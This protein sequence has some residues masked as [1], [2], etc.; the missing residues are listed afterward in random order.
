MSKGSSTRQLL[1]LYFHPVGT[2]RV[3]N[4]KYSRDMQQISKSELRFVAIK[5]PSK[6]TGKLLEL[7]KRSRVRKKLPY[8][9]IADQWT[10]P[11]YLNAA[12]QRHDHLRKQIVRAK[13]LHTKRT[14]ELTAA[15]EKAKGYCRSRKYR[16]AG[17]LL[18]YVLKKDFVGTP[19]IKGMKKLQS[20]INLYHER[21]LGKIVKNSASAA[22]L[23]ENLSKLRAK[24]SRYLPVYEKI[25]AAY[26]GAGSGNTS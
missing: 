18:H 17:N 26:R 10:N 2:Q 12:T 13:A 3:G 8:A 19:A 24:T 21:L 1:Y 23:R 5:I 7:L 14:G 22:K 4:F 16:E 15:L 6:P 20:Q 9:V 11:L 25:A